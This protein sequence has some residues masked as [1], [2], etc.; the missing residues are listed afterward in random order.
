[1]EKSLSDSDIRSYGINNVIQYEDLAKY[2]PQK[3]L[4]NLPLV[5]LYQTNEN[6]GH[7]VLLHRTPEGLEF[8]DSLG[9]KPDAEFKFIG[10]GMQQ[11]H[12][13]AQMLYDLSKVENINYNPYIFQE[14]RK[15]VATC[16]RHC[17]VRNMFSNY[18]IDDYAKGI[19]GASDKLG[20]TP[21]ELV[22]RMT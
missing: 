19:F 4:N 2:S 14:D 16:G 3:L 9:Y 7:W 15:N 11:P 18:G 21:D 1:M 12:Y 20:I 6:F 22:V 10:E 8:F 13:I 5:I 17:I